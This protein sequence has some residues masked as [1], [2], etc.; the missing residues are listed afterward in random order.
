MHDSLL[1]QFEIDDF[2]YDVPVIVNTP[3]YVSSG[4]R[5]CVLT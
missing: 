4:L 2:S 1:P 3:I 5:G